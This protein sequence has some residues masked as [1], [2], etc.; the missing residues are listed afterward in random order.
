MVQI[1]LKR[2]NGY[3]ESLKKK[4]T[5]DILCMCVCFPYQLKRLFLCSQMVILNS[6]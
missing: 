4:K 5:E 6:L 1:D 3:S 2:N